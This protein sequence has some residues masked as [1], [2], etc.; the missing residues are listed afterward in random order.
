MPFLE[1][2]LDLSP[3]RLG[4]YGQGSRA[5]APALP[6]ARP[7]TSGGAAALAAAAAVARADAAAGVL[8]LQ[9][10]GAAGPERGSA[11]QAGQGTP[12]PSN[13]PA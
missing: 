5:A 4:P 6:C 1:A 2:H 12:A 9:D 13:T 10:C 7:A 3:P 11:A 8:G